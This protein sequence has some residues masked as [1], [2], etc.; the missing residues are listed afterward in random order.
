MVPDIVEVGDGVANLLLEVAR[1]VTV[2]GPDP[3]FERLV[4][5]LDL[6]LRLGV[7][8]QII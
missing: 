4:L 6:S 1:R 7:R 5:A 3:L 8:R 2:F